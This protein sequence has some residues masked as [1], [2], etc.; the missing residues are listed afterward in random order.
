LAFAVGDAFCDKAI[1]FELD[2]LL[3]F[4]NKTSKHVELLEKMNNNKIKTD[5]PIGILDHFAGDS[6]INGK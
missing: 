1:R 6:L 3:E 5:G 2:R 4:V